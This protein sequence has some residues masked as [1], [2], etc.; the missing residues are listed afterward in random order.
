MTDNRCPPPPDCGGP[1]QEVIVEKPCPPKPWDP[2]KMYDLSKEEMRA[3]RERAKMREAL[4][5]EWQKKVTDPF[6]GSHDGGHIV[7]SCIFEFFSVG[8]LQAFSQLSA[9]ALFAACM[10]R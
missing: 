5:L 2:W 3:I 8:S 1:K 7:S 6:R 9:T 4:K 10:A